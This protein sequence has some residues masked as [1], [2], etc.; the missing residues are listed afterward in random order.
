MDDGGRFDDPVEQLRAWLADARSAT[1]D[2]DA[3]ALATA[4]STGRPSVRIVLLRGVDARGLTFFTNHS[5]RKADELETNPWAAATLHWW[6]L[7]RQV[8]VEG[9]VERTTDAESE[10]YWSTRPRGSQLAAWASRQSRTLRD[11]EE[12]AERVADA[13][14]RFAGADVPLPPFWGGYRILPDSI[15]FWT[16]RDDRLH[17]RTRYVREAGG[18]RREILAP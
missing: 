8:R 11:T 5:S 17:D 1:P 16:H 4:N 7:G 14:A 12:L 2:A 9:G 10:A 13:D 3:M 18:W 15:E 6:A